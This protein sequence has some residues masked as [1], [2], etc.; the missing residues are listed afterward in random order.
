MHF[1]FLGI[2][3]R[4]KEFIIAL[5]AFIISSLSFAL[6]YLANR[7]FNH[8]PIVIEKCSNSESQSK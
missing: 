7:E 6:G 5:V 2:F 1:D 3:F 8:A 4:K